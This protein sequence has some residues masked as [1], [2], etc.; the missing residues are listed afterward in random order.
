MSKASLKTTFEASRTIRPLYTGGS[1]A[2][3]ASGRI[4]VSCLTEDAIVVN[5]ETGDQLASLEGVSFP[6]CIVF[7]L[8][9]ANRRFAY[10]G[11][12]DNYQL[13]EYVLRSF[14]YMAP[15]DH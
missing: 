8:H 7:N 9:F 6:G 2:L 4:F 15:A 13:S 5:L 10:I 12:R 11:W 14:C 3:D 1:T